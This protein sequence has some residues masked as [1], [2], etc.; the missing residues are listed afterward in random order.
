MLLKPMKVQLIY[1]LFGNSFLIKKIDCR[2]NLFSLVNG[3]I[4][5]LAT[6]THALLSR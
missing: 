3:K 2:F 5:A 1:Q 6:I 4:P